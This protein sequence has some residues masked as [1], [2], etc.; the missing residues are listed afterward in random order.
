SDS[1]K[2]SNL[3]LRTQLSQGFDRGLDEVQL[4]VRAE[5]LGQNV[6]DARGL[7]HGRHEQHPGGPELAD[8]RVRDRSPLEL[9]PVHLLVSVLDAF[10]DGRGNLVGLAVT[11][12]HL[13][14]AVAD[15]D[16]GVE[17]ESPAALDHGRAPADRD[18][19]LGPLTTVSVSISC[20]GRHK[21]LL[22]KS[23]TTKVCLT[24]A[25]QGPI[26]AGPVH[27]GPRI[28]LRC[29][30]RLRSTFFLPPMLSS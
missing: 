6:L 10:L 28:A 22:D 14:S 4:V 24:A 2:A 19:A 16:Q 1:P 20:V 5:A 23:T 18:H 9:D 7:D 21:L 30:S 11:P 3:F 27:Y 17:A 12:G 15:D 25:R 8:H 29:C 26:Y 13:S